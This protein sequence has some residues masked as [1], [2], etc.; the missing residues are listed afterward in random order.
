MKYLAVC[1]VGIVLLAGGVAFAN[2]VE[3]T[4]Q[5][6][7]SADP[8]HTVVVLDSGATLVVDDSTTVTKDGQ[9]ARLE[10]L[11]PGAKVKAS[12]NEQDGQNVASTLDLQK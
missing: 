4:I 9:Q 11:Q 5:A 8:S 1:F 2:D 6:I 10:D 12:Y 7:Q 3:G